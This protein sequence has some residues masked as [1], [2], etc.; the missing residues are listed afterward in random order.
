MLINDVVNFLEMRFPRSNAED[1]DQPRIGFVVGSKSIEVNNILLSLDLTYEV[2]MEAINKN[3]NMIITHHPFIW[4]PLYKL[5]FDDPK[6]QIISKLFKH[7]ISV[8]SMHTNLDVANGGVNDVLCSMLNVNEIKSLYDEEK[9]NFLKFGEI[10]E[11]TLKEF[12]LQVKSN[13]KLTGVRVFGDLNKKVKNIGI[14]GGSGAHIG[15]LNDAIK[16]NLDAYVTGEIKLS[17]AQYAYDNGLALVEVNHGVEK[18][19]FDNV[20]TIMIDY[21]NE[22]Y[23]FQNNIYVSE[24]DTDKFITL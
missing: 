14:I 5:I 21:L 16:A 24:I 22:K 10:N 19:V 12:A 4:D 6:T 2:V 1:F 13:F 11:I 7:K 17:N 15:D 9:G 8:Y 23:N 3:C 18:F 20:K